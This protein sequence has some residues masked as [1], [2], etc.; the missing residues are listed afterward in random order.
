MYTHPSPRCGDWQDRPPAGQTTAECNGGHAGLPC[1][2]TQQPALASTLP[3]ETKKTL[4]RISFLVTSRIS[5]VTLTSLPIVGGTRRKSR[6]LKEREP[7]SD[8]RDGQRVRRSPVGS[9]PV[10]LTTSSGGGVPSAELTVPGANLRGG[11]RKGCER[12]PHSIK[13]P[14][15][16]V[17]HPRCVLGQSFSYF[18]VR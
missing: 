1:S 4:C 16:N 5:L 12:G 3:G 8:G 11:R 7:R 9:G 13:P 2:E 10:F 18:N 6:I 17:H 14:G 15:Q